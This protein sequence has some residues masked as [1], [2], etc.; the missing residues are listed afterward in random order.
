[1]A[2]KIQEDA[3]RGPVQDPYAPLNGINATF[4]TLPTPLYQPSKGL[5]AC[6]SVRTA[7]SDDEDAIDSNLDR[8]NYWAPCKYIQVFAARALIEGYRPEGQLVHI[9]ERQ[10]STRSHRR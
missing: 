6:R 9:P 3:L 4:A 8:Q 2:A 7:D 5:S 1:M 10:H